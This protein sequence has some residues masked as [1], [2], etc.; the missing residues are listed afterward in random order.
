[1][2]NV[3]RNVTTTMAIKAIFVIRVSVS[4]MKWAIS[5][6]VTMMSTRIRQ[7]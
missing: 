3:R 1:M 4:E 5:G 7:E 2:Q 6:E